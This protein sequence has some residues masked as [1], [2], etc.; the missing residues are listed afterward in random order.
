MKIIR[1]KHRYSDFNWL[2]G[3]RPLRDRQMMQDL[4]SPYIAIPTQENLVKIRPVFPEN[5]W[6]RGRTLKHILTRN[7]WQSLAY[8]PLGAP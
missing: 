5:S 7:A 6:L 3:Q 1:E 2:P 8:S 4:S